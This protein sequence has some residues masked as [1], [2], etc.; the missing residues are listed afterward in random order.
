M[1]KQQSKQG[2]WRVERSSSGWWV[3]YGDKIPFVPLCRCKELEYANRIANTMNALPEMIEFL[4]E[5][6][7]HTEEYGLSRT[8]MPTDYATKAK[9]IIDN[10]EKCDVQT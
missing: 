10:L 1:S 2:E 8:T 5:I 3:K 6:S 4:K 9:A 7:T